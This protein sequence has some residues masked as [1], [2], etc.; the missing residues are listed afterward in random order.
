VAL[1]KN[2]SPD[3]D[4]TL[5]FTRGSVGA[6]DGSIELPAG[7]LVEFLVGFANKVNI[8]LNKIVI[9]DS[10]T[11]FANLSSLLR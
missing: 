8:I 10:Y 5:F 3:A 11:H 1:D 2:V 9:F 7:K 6:V 4:T